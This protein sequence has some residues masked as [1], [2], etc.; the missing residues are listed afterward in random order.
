MGSAVVRLLGGTGWSYWGIDTQPGEES[1]ML[2]YKDAQGSTQT[3]PGWTAR[4]LSFYDDDDNKVG[5]LEVPAPSAP[6]T[7]P[8]TPP[9]PAPEYQCP[10]PEPYPTIDDLSGGE[11]QSA[12]AAM[13]LAL[14]LVILQSEWQTHTAYCEGLEA[15]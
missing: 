10:N 11:I 7:N 4:S 13:A 3:V 12:Q 8:C 6:V 15:T 14:L 9:P 2:D 5:V 1:L